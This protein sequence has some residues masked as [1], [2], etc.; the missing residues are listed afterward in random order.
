METFKRKRVGQTAVSDNQSSSVTHNVD[1]ADTFIC[2]HV[3]VNDI[4]LNIIFSGRIRTL[5]AMATYIL[6][7]LIMEKVEIDNIFCLNR[8]IW[9]FFY[10]N[11]Y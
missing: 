3:H 5:V 7:R 8:D 6:H 11:V 9:S 2:I 10:R 4:S 1:E